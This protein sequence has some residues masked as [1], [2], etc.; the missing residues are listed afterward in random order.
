MVIHNKQNNKTNL[1][2]QFLRFLLCF[3]IVVSHCSYIKPKHKKYIH[4]GFHVPTFMFIAFYFYY[5][6]LSKRIISKIVSRFQRLLV[7]YLFWPIL[8]IIFRNLS[9]KNFINGIIS[10][11]KEISSKKLFLQVL[12][13][14]PI[15][16][17]FWFQFNL[18]FLSLFITI[19]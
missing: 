10:F 1:G 4:K 18:L 9:L 11:I 14:T 17:I 3:W 7:P 5:P 6:I 19:Q 8:K 12:I 13:G 15:H 16:G 2:I